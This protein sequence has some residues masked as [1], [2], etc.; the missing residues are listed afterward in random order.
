MDALICLKL[1]LEC[2]GSVSSYKHKVCV[3]VTDGF[4]FILGEVM[5]WEL[6][7]PFL[8]FIFFRVRAECPNWPVEAYSYAVTK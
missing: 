7:L 6:A 3:L 4:S 5:A 1:E 8:F 2:G